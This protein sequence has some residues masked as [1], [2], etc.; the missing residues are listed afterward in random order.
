MKITVLGSGTSTGIPVIGCSCPV[1]LSKNPR[2]KRTRCS[3]LVESEEGSLL[4]DTPPELRLQLLREGVKDIDGVLYTHAHADHLHG[5]DDLRTLSHGKSL[6]LYGAENIL[7]EIEGRFPYIFKV[8][9]QRGGGKPCLSLFPLSETL[10][11]IG[12]DVTPIPV[13]HGIIPIYGYRFNDFVYI[14]DCSRIPEKSLTL[15]EG[16]R[17]M[18]LG[19]LRYLPHETHFSIDE[20]LAIIKKTGPERAW[21]THICHDVNHD[22]LEKELPKPVEPAYDGLSFIC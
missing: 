5:I 11:T 8:T 12:L 7:S 22:R 15:L 19:G 17:A 4:V 13:F 16:C 9:P 2:N 1:C 21:L 20:A 6:P 10:H 14:T 18:I 3:L